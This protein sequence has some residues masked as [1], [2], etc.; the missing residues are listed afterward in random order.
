[1]QFYHI[2]EALIEAVSLFFFVNSSEIFEFSLARE[3]QE[4]RETVGQSYVVS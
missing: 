3:S 4:I 1:M 2:L